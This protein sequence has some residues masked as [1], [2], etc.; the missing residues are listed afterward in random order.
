MR[1]QR[2]TVGLVKGARTQTTTT[3]AQAGLQLPHVFHRV[4]AGRGV[5]DGGEIGRVGG[6]RGG[7]DASAAAHQYRVGE[8]IGDRGS[9]D[10]STDAARANH[11]DDDGLGAGKRVLTGHPGCPVAR[12]SV[13]ARTVPHARAGSIVNDA[14]ASQ[15]S[16]SSDWAWPV[17]TS[18]IGGS[19]STTS[20]GTDRPLAR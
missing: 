13:P 19:G 18:S 17:A 10:R 14:A 7:L 9:S 20:G 6:Q 12:S 3:R 15:A 11:P 16:P 4:D 5:L 8:A 1:G 2:L